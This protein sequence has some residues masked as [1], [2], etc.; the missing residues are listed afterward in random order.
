[1]DFRANYSRGELRFFSRRITECVIWIC[2]ITG[3]VGLGYMVKVEKKLD[4]EKYSPP[5][6]LA[7]K[8]LGPKYVSLNSL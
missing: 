4:V 5:H 8:R 3:D 7:Q 2:F 1:M 6:S